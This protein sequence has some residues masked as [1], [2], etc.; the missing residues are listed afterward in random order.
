MEIKLCETCGQIM[1]EPLDTKSS[2]GR[3]WYIVKCLA[4]FPG[5]EAFLAYDEAEAHQ[6]MNKWNG[7]DLDISTLEVDDMVNTARG[8]ELRLRFM[9]DFKKKQPAKWKRMK[10]FI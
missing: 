6:Q 8:R 3:E 1:K 10:E 9:D 7:C 5:Y 4:H 2:T